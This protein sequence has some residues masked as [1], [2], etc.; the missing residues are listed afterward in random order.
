[1]HVV[2]KLVLPFLETMA[3]QVCNLS[4][5]GC[6]NYSDLQHKGYTPWKELEEDLTRWL[7]VFDIPDFGIMG[8]EPLINPEIHEWLYG[9]RRLLPESQIRFTTNGILL[10]RHLDIIDVAHE[11]GNVVFKITAHTDVDDTIDKIFKRYKWEPVTEFGI[12]RWK[13]TNG[14]RFQVNRPEK[15]V[16]TY[17]D[18]Y[19]NMLPWDSNAVE[20]FDLCIQQRCPLLYRGRIYKCSTQGLLEDTLI[21]LGNP[22]K[23]RWDP[24]LGHSIS[25]NDP[26]EKLSQFVANF[27]KP[28]SICRMCPTVKD[29]DALVNH[30]ITVI[31][32]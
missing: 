16:K 21:R 14:L 22:N 25:P 12:Q 11:I 20:S 28:H 7:E 24:Y 30:K 18:S 5:L 10:N 17:R 2:S 32:K 29:T 9:V 15:F 19:N 3:T 13:T 8:G 27:G 26:T 4:C 23:E 1:M 6:T 31:R